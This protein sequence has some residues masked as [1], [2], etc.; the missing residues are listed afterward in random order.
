MTP[1]IHQTTNAEYHAERESL[2]KGGIDKLLSS[3]ADFLVYRTH[4]E[5][6]TPQMVFGSAFHTICLEPERESKEIQ[7]EKSV[8]KAARDYAA[9]QGIYLI[10]EED[11]ETLEEMKTS[12]EKS[13]NWQ[14]L[15]SAAA[16]E[17]TV[18]WT[19][20]VFGFACKCRPDVMAEGFKVLADLKTTVSALPE[21]FSKA[22]ANFN[23]DVQAHWY[24][25]GVSAVSGSQWT[26]FLFFAVEKTPPYKVGIYRADD[27]MLENGRQKCKRARGL[28]AQCLQTGRWEG[29]PDRIADIGLPRWAVC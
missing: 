9:E 18:T 20:P 22:C 12:L 29:L 10:S 5:P 17:Q 1:G 7:V 26:D 15:I 2:T 14:N 27:V 11:R 28:Y 4:R 23:Y 13:S 3:P 19:D 6:P 16:V 24:L 21:D 8:K 25:E